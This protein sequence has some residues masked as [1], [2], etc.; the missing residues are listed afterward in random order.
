VEQTPQMRARGER[1]LRWSNAGHPPPLLVGPDGRARYLESEPDL[2]IGLAPEVPRTEH[3]VPLEAGSTLLVFTDGL[4]ERRGADLAVG[5]D[6]LA[7]TVEELNALTVEEIC[8]A[9]LAQVGDRVEDDVAIVA[10]RA[11]PEDEPRPA[12]AGPVVSP[13]GPAA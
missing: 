10:L 2:L 1:R 7:R 12:E 8:D 11:Y 4:V 13:V 6:W 5:L 3:S 9:L